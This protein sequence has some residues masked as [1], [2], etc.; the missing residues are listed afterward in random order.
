MIRKSPTPTGDPLPTTRS[1]INSSVGG[2][3]G[4]IVTRGFTE[5]SALS[6][7]PAGVGVGTIS[8]EV[9]ISVE[10]SVAADCPPSFPQPSSNMPA[11][12]TDKIFR[13]LR[14]I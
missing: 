7:S 6:T 2:V 14:G 4:G 8:M 9:G 12:A 5:R 11:V 3:D 13:I 10:E 1:S